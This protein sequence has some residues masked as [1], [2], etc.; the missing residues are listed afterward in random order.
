MDT[1]AI[2]RRPGRNFDEGITTSSLGKPDFA[3]ALRQHEAYCKALVR[4]GL[5]LIVLEADE[6]YPD[7]CFLRIPHDGWWT[8]VT[9]AGVLDTPVP[10]CEPASQG[11]LPLSR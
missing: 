7:G 1:K 2:V 5:S 8:D 6:L 9:V 4:C 11:G 10:L 3:K